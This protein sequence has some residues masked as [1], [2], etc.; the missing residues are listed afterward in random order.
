MRFNLCR[1]LGRLLAVLGI[2]MAMPALAQAA[3]VLSISGPG[4]VQRGET[5][6]LNVNGSAAVDLFAYQFSLNFDRNAFRAVDVSEGPFLASG[7]ATFFDGGTIDNALGTVSFVLDT[8]LGA[9][10]GVNGSGVLSTVRFEVL[11]GASSGVFS[12]SDVIALNSSLADLGAQATAYI[13][14]VPEPATL[15]L[16]LLGAG[17]ATGVARRR[18]D[19]LQRATTA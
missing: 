9:G 15:L 8:L 13:Q 1:R 10:P 18:A 3:P 17:L 12:F 11:G 19:P 5:L 14:A 2:A 6:V 16:L 4:A 7:S